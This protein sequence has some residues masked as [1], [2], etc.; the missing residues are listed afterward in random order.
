[1]LIPQWAVW[2]FFPPLHLH[3]EKFIE[4]RK[5]YNFMF[6]LNNASYIGAD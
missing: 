4:L 1:M 6:T 3:V 2:G 5:R